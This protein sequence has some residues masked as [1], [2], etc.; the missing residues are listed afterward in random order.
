[1]SNFSYNSYRLADFVTDRFDVAL[2]I[3]EPA[4]GI[5]S[6]ELFPGLPTLRRQSVS[7]YVVPVESRTFSFIL[8]FLLAPEGLFS[9]NIFDYYRN[10]ALL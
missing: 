3:S 6:V 2:K 10:F 4:L 5:V 1:M 9:Y 7:S 8:I